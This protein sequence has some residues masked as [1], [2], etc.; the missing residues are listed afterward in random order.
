MFKVASIT[1]RLF[2][3]SLMANMGSPNRKRVNL[4]YLEFYDFLIY[5]LYIITAFSLLCSEL[6]ACIS[7]KRATLYCTNEIH[8]IG[9]P[10]AD[11]GAEHHRALLENTSKFLMSG[12]RLSLKRLTSMFFFKELTCSFEVFSGARVV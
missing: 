5:V 1:H 10:F 11:L 7:L 4:K 3:G 12:L 6:A 9:P 8:R 2:F